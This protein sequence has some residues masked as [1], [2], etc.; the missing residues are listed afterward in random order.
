MRLE[1]GDSLIELHPFSGRVSRLTSR[2]VGS[3]EVEP[4]WERG[5]DYL[6]TGS[7]VDVPPS[8]WDDCFVHQ[9]SPDLVVPGVGRLQLSAETSTWVVFGELVETICV[10]PQTAPPN[11][12]N[13]DDAR[14]APVVAPGGRAELSLTLEWAPEG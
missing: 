11:T 3:W 2:S 14:V 9:G 10:E 4:M 13:L 1:A 7:L 12:F 8:P 5:A 6:P